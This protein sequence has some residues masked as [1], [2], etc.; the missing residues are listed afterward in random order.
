[1]GSEGH[2]VEPTTSKPGRSSRSRSAGVV[3]VATWSLIAVLWVAPVALGLI[4]ITVALVR[5]G[6]L[7]GVAFGLVVSHE[8]GHALV[9]TTNPNA[10]PSRTPTRTSAT[11]I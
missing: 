10:T 1:M 11:V 9:E 3:T 4:P 2:R 7:L 8:L 5:V 6:V